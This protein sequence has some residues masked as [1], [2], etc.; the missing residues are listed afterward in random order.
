VLAL[1]EP[2]VALP[3]TIIEGI[4]DRRAAVLT[5]LGIDTLPKLAQAEPAVI[6]GAM[7]GVDEAI[8]LDFISQAQRI[9][10]QGP[11]A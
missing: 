8:A 6:A 4:G 10:G 3:L 2:A 5:N 11:E 1:A 7:R 9:L